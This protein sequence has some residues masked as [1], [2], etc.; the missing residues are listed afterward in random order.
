MKKSA[1]IFSFLTI[2]YLSGC[3][4][5]SKSANEQNNED[6]EIQNAEEIKENSED[7]RK[8][9]EASEKEIDKLLN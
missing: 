3:D 9:A 1:F 5:N 4:S 2:V 7:A 8:S 6:L